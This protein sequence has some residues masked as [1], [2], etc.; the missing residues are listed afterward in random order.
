[1]KRFYC[2]LIFFICGPILFLCLIFRQWLSPGINNPMIHPKGDLRLGTFIANELSRLLRP[3]IPT[4][5]DVANTVERT[6]FKH[7]KEFCQKVLNGTHQLFKSKECQ[8]SCL[9]LNEPY[10]RRNVII[11]PYR[12]R[13]EHLMKLIPRLVELLTKQ[14]LCYLLIVVE[15]IDQQPFNK[16]V[17]MNTG[18]VEALNWL[19]FHCAIFHDVDLLPLNNEVDYTCSIYPKHLSLC[20]DKFQNRLPYVEL[21]GGVLSMPLKA[22]LRVNG[23]SNLFWGWGA[24]D[25]DM[26]ER[27]M[28]NGIPVIRPDPNVAQFI[29]LKHK[30]SPAFHSAL[31]TQILSFTKVRYRLDGI[32][33]L[34]Y[35]LV[36]SRIK[37][38][39]QIHSSINNNVSTTTDSSHKINAFR[40]LSKSNYPI[41]HLKIDVGKPPVEFI[42]KNSFT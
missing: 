38:Y 19:P 3:D 22:F 39:N 16:G 34:N 25:D 6:W 10:T 23:Y 33:N 41:L 4:V 14:K 40:S 27:L 1:M 32:N 21:I 26:Y 31:R 18:F 5:E 7:Q 37:L 29:M 8:N 9:T 15:Q 35:T 2:T 13:A 30:P 17:L 20:V 28:I 42:Q 24:E 36:E 12:S 11:I